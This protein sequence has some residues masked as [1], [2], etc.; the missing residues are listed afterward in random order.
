MEFKNFAKVWNGEKMQPAKKFFFSSKILIGM[1]TSTD[2]KQIRGFPFLI[3][4][5]SLMSLNY[6]YFLHCPWTY[7]GDNVCTVGI[8]A[9][10]GMFPHLQPY[11]LEGLLY[12]P[13]VKNDFTKK[14][15]P[16]HQPPLV[17]ADLNRSQSRIGPVEASWRTA[18][19][20]A[21]SK[22]AFVNNFGRHLPVLG[23]VD[24]V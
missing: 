17:E 24:T 8:L 19:S 10:T 3:F 22:Q 6:H 23:V 4:L 9:T 5:H 18:C 1:V 16:L 2:Q 7:R 12:L 14:W 15:F 13:G 20:L 21:R 11:E